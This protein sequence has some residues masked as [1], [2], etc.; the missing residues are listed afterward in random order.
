MILLEMSGGS[1]SG[2]VA[3]IVLVMIGPPFLFLVLGLVFLH[4]HPK[5]SKT[6][7]I[8]MGVYL[9]IAGGVCGTFLSS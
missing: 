6:F 9:L 2:L 4:K 7:F 1:L 8:L 5:R 3:L